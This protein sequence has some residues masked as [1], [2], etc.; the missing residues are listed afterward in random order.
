MILVIIT[1]QIN[2]LVLVFYD[3][4]LSNEKKDNS[5]TKYS[6]ITHVSESLEPDQLRFLNKFSDNSDEN[7]FNILLEETHQ[8]G[9]S[10]LKKKTWKKL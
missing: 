6:E 8:I 4:E 9:T 2:L 7:N 1:Y 10:G 3:S 5:D